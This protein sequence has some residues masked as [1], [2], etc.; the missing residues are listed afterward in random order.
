M[1]ASITV[2][3]LLL[4]IFCNDII[5]CSELS[6]HEE[7]EEEMRLSHKLNAMVI[8]IGGREEIL[9]PTSRPDSHHENIGTVGFPTVLIGHMSLY[10]PELFEKALFLICSS[11][12]KLDSIHVI[13]SS[14][15]DRHI[16]DINV[17]KAICANVLSIHS[18]S[19]HPSKCKHKH[20]HVEAGYVKWLV[21]ELLSA[22]S[23]RDQTL[24]LAYIR[25]TSGIG[26]K[27]ESFLKRHIN[28]FLMYSLSLKWLS[29]VLD[30]LAGFPAQPDLLQKALK[31]AA[32]YRRDQSFAAISQ[33]LKKN[34]QADRMKSIETFITEQSE[35]LSKPLIKRIRSDSKGHE[36]TDSDDDYKSPMKKQNS[37]F[38]IV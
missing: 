4:V 32:R 18:D 30:I 21:P 22:V 13:L 14:F 7:D 24:F 15:L 11:Y 20:E 35:I 3:V 10:E 12:N 28:T 33:A 27:S 5:S 1:I 38:F 16:V 25:L 17:A 36:E 23:N 19:H 8:E 31:Q 29:G 34:I 2:L 26:M 6:V 9:D 37:R